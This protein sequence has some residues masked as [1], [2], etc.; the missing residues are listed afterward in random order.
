MITMRERLE[1]RE[2][3]IRPKVDQPIHRLRTQVKTFE[4]LVSFK[5]LDFKSQISID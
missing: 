4:L 1:K 2:F 5:F 3:K